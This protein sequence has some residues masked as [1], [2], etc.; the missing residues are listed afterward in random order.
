MPKV[1]RLMSGHSVVSWTLPH[2]SPR[3]HPP[4]SMPTAKLTSGKIL[5]ES[6]NKLMNESKDYISSARKFYFRAV[7]GFWRTNKWVTNIPIC[8]MGKW[9]PR[10]PGEDTVPPGI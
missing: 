10:S 3:C 8:Q 6:K 7:S 9:S 5:V 1:T 4:T 2:I